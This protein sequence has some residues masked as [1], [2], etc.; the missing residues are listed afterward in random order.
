MR[1]DA[2]FQR[3]ELFVASGIIAAH[4]T[5]ESDGFRQRDLRF[6][7]EL[8]S[9]WVEITLDGLTLELN[10]TQ[11]ARYLSNLCDEGYARR[12]TRKGHPRYHLTRTGVLE[13]LRRISERQYLPSPE[14]MFFL[15]YFVRNY[16]PRIQALVE[17]QG[18]KFPLELRLE[19]EELL[20]ID[21]ILAREEDRAN[22]ELQKLDARIRDGS[23]TSAMAKKLITGDQDIDSAVVEIEKHFPYELNSQ[24][25]LT[26]LI[27][28]LP[29]WQKEWELKSGAMLRAQQIWLPT[30]SMLLA[31]IQILKRLQ[32]A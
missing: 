9:N 7:I 16:G 20:N 3:H 26:E 12:V 24:K 17:K 2:L 29:D 11:V 1:K 25:P 28:A 13:M 15:N 10:N 30:R 22:R 27:A 5:F 18:S 14:H 31:Y 23:K 21:A 19:V 4:S 6:F 32:N 8:F